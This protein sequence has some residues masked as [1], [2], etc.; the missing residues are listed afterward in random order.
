MELLKLYII[1]NIITII[2][3][4]KEIEAKIL[5]FIFFDSLREIYFDICI[6][7]D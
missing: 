7:F 1:K 3:T 6:I 2:A 4:S 5:F